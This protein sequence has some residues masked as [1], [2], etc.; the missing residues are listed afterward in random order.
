LTGLR[1]KVG[2][3]SGVTVEQHEGQIK[4][5]RTKLLDL[6]GLWSLDGDESATSSE[7]QR[8]A[9]RALR[10]E[11]EGQARPE[12]VLLILDATQLHRQMA[13][14][15]QV[16]AHKLPTLVVVNMVD[17]L[18][19]R[20]GYLDPLSLAQTLNSPVAMISAG[21][22]SGMEAIQRFVGAKIAPSKAQLL[23]VMQPHVEQRHVGCPRSQSEI[24]NE[25][26]YRRPL[27]SSWSRRIDRVALHPIYGPAMFFIVT[28][29]VFQT[30]FRVAAPVSNL[31]QKLLT[32]FGVWFGAFLPVGVVH[33]LVI[34]GL[35]MGVVSVLT[36]LPLILLLFLVI[37]LLEDT[38]YM[39]RAAVIAD[40]TMYRFGLSGRSFLPLLSAY[41]CAVPAIMATRTISSR[42]D[43]LTT[44]L[45][46]PFMTC[47]ARLPLYTMIIAAFIPDRPVVGQFLGLRACAMLGLYGIGMMAALVTSRLLHFSLL[48]KDDS[49]FA[50]ELP[51][52]RLPLWR[53][54]G[55]NL[56]DR[57][58]IFVRQVGT[59]ILVTSLG[60]WMLANFP[61]HHGQLSPI[62][63]SYLGSIGN[64]IEPALKPLGL[65]RNVGV[66]LLTA[67]IARETVVSTL[68]T[69]YQTPQVGIALRHSIGL[70][71]ALSLLVF[72]A[73]A[74]QCTSTLATVKRETNS[75]RWPIFQFVYMSAI[76]YIAAWIT[77][78]MS[79]WLL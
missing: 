56:L 46:A 2:N 48:R 37:A 5:T 72:F 7:D 47:S 43:R 22:G 18:A 66:A 68:G 33:S 62:G 53:S 35:W 60:V 50:I 69:L 25:G 20:E 52:Y 49:A 38:G 77:F 39:A 76:A 24:E 75:W 78:R 74:M 64:A 10:G 67:F 41:A 14:A 32:A 28:L 65:D 6:P 23:P 40:R 8:I 4:G 63:E 34:D 16:I 29:G 73:L 9:V 57:A 19:A 58:R 71:G 61:V 70:A 42:R 15:R 59:I 26:L 51:E 79:L 36:Y 27:P 12:A 17:V 30:I 44:I 3:Y 21:T 11:I 31:F 1:Q 54:L 13:L 55:I 45:V